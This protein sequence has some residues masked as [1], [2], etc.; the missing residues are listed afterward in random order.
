MVDNLKKGDAEYK[1]LVA[2]ANDQALSADE[3]EKNKKAAD[4]KLKDLQDT[5]ANLDE[6]DRAAKSRLTDKL[7]RMHD[8]IL[9]EIRAA[10]AAK[11]KAGGYNMVF[12]SGAQGVSG[13]SV[14]VY[15]SS[16]ADLTDDIIK[17]LNI[18]APVNWNAAPASS[19][20]LAP[21]MVT[22]NRF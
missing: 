19:A 11:S 21:S 14:L 18:G 5:K 8:G 3:R 16:Q 9:A 12:D 22:T 13:A 7:Q 2:A 20:P 15:N 17:Q 10:V 6:Y 1:T 4:A